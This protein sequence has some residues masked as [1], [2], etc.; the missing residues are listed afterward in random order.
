MAQSLE[1]WV[2]NEVL[3]LD[4]RSP[5]WLSDV[6]FFR[7]PRRPRTVDSSYFFS[8]ADGVI[9]YQRTVK[10]DEPILDIK[11]ES[12]SLRDAL[13]EPEYHRESLVIGI[14]MTFFDVHVNRVPYRG[15]LS[16]RELPPIHTYNRPMLDVENRLLYD[17]QIDLSEASYLRPNQRMVNRVYAPALGETYRMLQIADYDVSCITP[18][19]LQQNIP[20]Q[21]GARFSQIRYG[22]QVDLVIPLS[23]RYQLTPVHRESDHVKAGLDRLVH[24]AHHPAGSGAGRKEERPA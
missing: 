6:Y 4:D 10:P 18:F 1:E 3:R 19:R 7:D 14:F 24:V 5:A 17:L 21:Q 23:D 11:G 22:S 15:T 2:E 8:P 12:Y 20:V 9:L 16:Y 13:R